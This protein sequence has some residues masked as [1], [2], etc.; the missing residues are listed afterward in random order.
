MQ[1]YLWRWGIDVNFRDEKQL[2][3]LGEAQV[4]NAASNQ[5]QAASIAAAYSLLWVAVL[6]GRE[7]GAMFTPLKWRKQGECSG[8]KDPKPSTGELQRQMR[9]EAW[10]GAS[11]AESLSHFSHEAS[12]VTKL[13]KPRPSLS[14]AIFA[15]A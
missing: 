5:H 8:E 13:E 12:R 14:G 1:H 6:Q 11:R 10:A 9:Y 15:P 2:V 3:G 7:A 4:R